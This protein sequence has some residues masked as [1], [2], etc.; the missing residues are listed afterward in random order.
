MF[1]FL[2]KKVHKNSTMSKHSVTDKLVEQNQLKIFSLWLVVKYP[3]F[4][5]IYVFIHR[6]NCD[7][8]L[9]G[10]Q[11]CPKGALELAKWQ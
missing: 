7:G 6:I 4:G 9:N 2:L 3:K 8:T 11:V 10:A 1:V 5:K